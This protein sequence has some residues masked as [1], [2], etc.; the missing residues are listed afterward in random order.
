MRFRRI[1]GNIRDLLSYGAIGI[2]CVEGI[3][4]AFESSQFPSA[5]RHHWFGYFVLTCTIAL[6]ARFRAW[7]QESQQLREKTSGVV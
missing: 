1:I 3:S 7:N 5:S 2:L 6:V 4:N